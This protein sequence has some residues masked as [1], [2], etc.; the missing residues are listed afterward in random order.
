MSRYS[1]LDTATQRGV[2]CVRGCGVNSIESMCMLLQRLYSVRS[3]IIYWLYGYGCG[4]YGD[5]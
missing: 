4:M 5:G 2:D 1:R 3:A